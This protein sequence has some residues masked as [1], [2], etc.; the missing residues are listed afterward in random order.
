M[1][2]ETNGSKVIGINYFL[3]RVRAFVLPDLDALT[4]ALLVTDA[5][6]I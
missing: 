3:Q 5:G 2:Q 6:K 4:A 1:E